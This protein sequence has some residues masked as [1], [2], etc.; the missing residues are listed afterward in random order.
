MSFVKMIIF[1][2]LVVGIVGSNYPMKQV[3][4]EPF[5]TTY[6]RHQLNLDIMQKQIW[7]DIEGYKSQYKISDYGLIKSFKG[8]NPILIKQKISKSGYL[9]ICLHNNGNRKFYR[10][11]RLV[12][13]TF[14]PRARIGVEKLL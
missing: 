6:S 10:T 8:R 11:S 13:L 3:S 7:E 9:N 14:I 1:S 4:L 12:A 5:P 2:I